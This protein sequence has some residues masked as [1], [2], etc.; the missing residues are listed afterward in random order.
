LVVLHR[1]IW[2]ALMADSVWILVAVA[3]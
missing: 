2:L 1:L 3:D